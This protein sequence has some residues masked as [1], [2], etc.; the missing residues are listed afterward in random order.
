MGEDIRLLPLAER[1]AYYRDMA[2][3]ALHRANA[4]KEGWQREQ[5][6]T[7]AQGWHTL[8]CELEKIDG[9]VPGEP[10]AP[11]ALVQGKRA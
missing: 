4:C 10:V 6:F 9:V 1:A 7:L 5:F 11:L 2:L 8:A 3:D